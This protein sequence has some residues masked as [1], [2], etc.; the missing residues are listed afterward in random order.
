MSDV[1]RRS[2]STPGPHASRVQPLPFDA[3]WVDAV[4]VNLSATERR[5]AGHQ[6]RRTVKKQWQAAWLLK[7][8]SLMDLT[9]LSG[10]D[11]QDR[12]RRLSAKALHPVRAD[13]L[14]ALGWAGRPL[15]TGA[16]C[17]Y[18]EMVPAA[19]AALAGSGVPVA[20]VST[21]FPAGLT[22]LDLRLEEIRR[23]LQTIVWFLSL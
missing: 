8:V 5:I 16:V 6:G 2:P 21:G 12:I 3:A 17:V 1:I 4:R 9:T 7:A 11:T 18:H 10:D 13:L 20:A 14:S 15:T 23:C 19:V 22:P